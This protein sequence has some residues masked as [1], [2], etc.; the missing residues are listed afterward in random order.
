LAGKDLF[1]QESGLVVAPD[2]VAAVF[3]LPP[4]TGTTFLKLELRDATGKMVS[5][6]FYWIPAKLAVLDWK[7]TTY[8]NTPAV[9]YADMRDLAGLPRAPVQASARMG[10]EQGEVVVDL[11]NGGKSVAFFVHVRAVKAGTE[12]EIAPVFWDDNFVSLLPGDTR[13]LTVSGLGLPRHCEIKIDGWNVDPRS[14]RVAEVA[15]GGER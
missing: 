8:V 14:F 12:E 4:Q 11:R 9:S 10:K 13:V 6:N 1:R 7:K 15:V 2:G 5:E 3:A